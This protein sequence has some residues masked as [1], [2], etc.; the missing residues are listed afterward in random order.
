MSL[1][2]DRLCSLVVVKWWSIKVLEHSK[3][4]VWRRFIY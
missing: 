2:N 1:I 3:G 4:L